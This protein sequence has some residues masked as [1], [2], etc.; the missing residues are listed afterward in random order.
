MYYLPA[1]QPPKQTSFVRLVTHWMVNL[2]LY[3]TK[4]E[5][6]AMLYQHVVRH[7][8]NIFSVY[9]KTLQLNFCNLL[10]HFIFALSVQ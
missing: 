4:M 8:S 1:V 9:L 6:G 10:D 2:L 3:A 7:L 5:N